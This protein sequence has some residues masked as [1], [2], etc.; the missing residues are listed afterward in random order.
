MQ[1]E[2]IRSVIR[3]FSYFSYPP[4]FEELYAFYPQKISRN[5]LKQIVNDLVEKG[6]LIE[7]VVSTNN[8]AKYTLPQ[9][10]IFFKKAVKRRRISAK[11][12]KT[13][14]R[15]ISFSH[16]T[17]S[18]QFVGIS[19]SVSMNNADV[20]DDIDLF[21]ITKSGELWTGRALSL[22]LAFI[23]GKRRSRGVIVAKDR[24]CLNLFFD[25]AHLSIP[26][27]KQT[28]YIAHEILQVKPILNK[29]G[30]YE[31]F[32]HENRWIQKYFP[33]VIVPRMHTRNHYQPSI[34]ST[35]VESCCRSI[36]WHIMKHHITKERISE[37]QLWFYPRDFEQQLNWKMNR[38][39]IV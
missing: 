6:V 37:G 20:N 31:Q 33:N 38:K 3:Y 13:I 30:T 8:E 1:N 39:D 9:Y 17:P 35:F 16:Y 12:R 18:I 21:I 24:V 14:T 36:Q 34:I 10:G 28:L 2:S 15:F 19:G 27:E 23:L 5:S 22:A 25:R 7:Q 26:K 32:L 4:S 29:N 11:K